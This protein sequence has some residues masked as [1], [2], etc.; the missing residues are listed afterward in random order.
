MNPPCCTIAFRRSELAREAGWC[1]ASYIDVPLSSQSPAAPLNHRLVAFR[2]S[3]LAGDPGWSSASKTCTALSSPKP[4]TQ[5]HPRSDAFRRSGG[6]RRVLAPKA[7][8]E[9]ASKPDAALSSTR[10]TGC[11]LHGAS[12]FLVWLRKSNQK[13][14]HPNIRVLLRKT[15]L[16]PALLRGSSRRD[17]HVPSLLARH[18][19]LAPPYATP[20]LGLLKGIRDRVACKSV[21]ELKNNAPLFRQSHDRT[22]STKPPLSDGRMESLRRGASGMD[23]AKGLGV[24]PMKGHGWPLR[25]DP[26]S[27]DGMREAE[28]SETRMQGQAFLLTFFAFEKSES[29][30]RAKPAGRAEKSAAPYEYRRA[31][32][33]SRAS[34]LLRRAMN[35]PHE[36]RP[37]SLANKRVTPRHPNQKR[38]RVCA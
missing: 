33:A 12:L 8:L 32:T 36:S 9:W 6:G 23:A 34:S 27:N 20:P 15:S 24:P 17:I 38:P 26:R 28:R 22:D 3:Q 2:R 35:P 4:T 13:E 14:G 25:G 31:A 30:S 16:T 21:N 5:L 18:P 11:A 29:P 7:V 19:C 37:P 10:P 1:S